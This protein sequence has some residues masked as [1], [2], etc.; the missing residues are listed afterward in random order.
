MKNCEINFAQ[1][2][3]QGARTAA[4][5]YEPQNMPGRILA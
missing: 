4:N 5:Y 1:L 3:N 2:Q